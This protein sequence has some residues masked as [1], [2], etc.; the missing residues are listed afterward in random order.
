MGGN[1]FPHLQM[2][3]VQ[4]EDVLPTV[5]H[6][7]ESLALEGFTYE[8]ATQHM[9][10]S[11]GKQDT[12][13]DVDFALNNRRARFVGEADLPVFSLRRFAERAREVLPE[14]HVNS[15]GLKG[16]QVQ[17]AFPVA[18]DPTKGYV[19]VDFV[20]GQPRW[21]MFTHYSPGQDV[22][23]FKGVT[24][25]TMFGVLAKMRKDFEMYEDG[26]YATGADLRA[27]Y[28]LGKEEMRTARVG[29]QY[30]LERGLYR[31]YAVQKRPGQGPSTVTADEFETLVPQAPRFTRLG[32]VTD[33]D[34][35]LQLLFGTSVSL[36]DVATFEKCVYK[37]AECFPERFVEAKERFLEAMSR[38][39][40]NVHSGVEDLA[41]H[42]VWEGR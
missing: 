38:S 15:K 18:G 4:R 28:L 13:G 25:S 7:V 37:V 14:G 6:V 34:A 41:N 27:A 24:I 29:L 2:E 12:S 33:P 42:P 35:V 36:D 19:Q 20:A 22:S 11:T 16:G 31:K 3:R 8:Y 32:Y 30:D 9:M 10:G 23:P 39:S 1:A 21:L 5:Q 40:G 26:T 17:T